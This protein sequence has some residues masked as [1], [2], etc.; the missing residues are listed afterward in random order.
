MVKSF[1]R[2]LAVPLRIDLVTAGKPKEGEVGG[3]MAGAFVCSVFL[4]ELSEEAK[5]AGTS[6]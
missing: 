3:I 4:S 5:R 6:S 2:T 1:S